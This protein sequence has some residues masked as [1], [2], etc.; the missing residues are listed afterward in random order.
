MA[1][2]AL[3]AL[4]V[5][6]GGALWRLVQEHPETSCRLFAFTCSTIGQGA[7]QDSSSPLGQCPECVCPPPLIESLVPH[8]QPVLTALLEPR[9]FVEA[10]GVWIVVVHVALLWCCCYG[11]SAARPRRRPAAAVARRIEGAVPARLEAISDL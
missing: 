4:S 7:T 8:R 2:R 10:F 9:P 6:T 3:T 1:F 5:A 11:R